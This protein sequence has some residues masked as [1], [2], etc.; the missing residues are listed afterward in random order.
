MVLKIALEWEGKENVAVGSDPVRFHPDPQLKL[1]Q[2]NYVQKVQIQ[3]ILN[4]FSK[5]SKE[6]H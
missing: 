3:P 1:R 2:T 4:H 5:L 6:E